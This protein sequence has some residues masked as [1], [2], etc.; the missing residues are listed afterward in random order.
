MSGAEKLQTKVCYNKGMLYFRIFLPFS[1]TIWRPHL[2]LSWHTGTA[3]TQGDCDGMAYQAICLLHG[4]GGVEKDYSEGF[5]LLLE[6]ASDGSGM[7]CH[8]Y[9][10]H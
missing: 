9:P 1:H 8:P 6:A 2:L 3:T 7:T 5:E 4:Q 10:F